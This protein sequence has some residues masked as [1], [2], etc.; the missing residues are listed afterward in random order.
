[1]TGDCHVR[2]RERL[3]GKL[4]GPTRLAIVTGGASGIGLAT[5]QFFAMKQVKVIAV[6]LNPQV[7]SIVKTIDSCYIGIPG[8]LTEQTFRQHVVDTTIQT[9]GRIDILV[10][11]AGVAILN[12]AEL[13]TEDQWDKTMNINL[14]ASFMIAQLVGRRMISQGE[15]SIVNISSQASIVALDEH[16]AY[17]ASKAAIVSMSQVMA[18]E[19][20]NHGI[21]VNCISPTIV[22]TELGRNAWAGKKGEDMKLQIPA[23]RFAETDE[24]AASIAFLC[25]NA[26]GMITGSNLIIDG[27]YTAR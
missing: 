18:Y 6:D 21:R 8:D 16:V 27:G 12:K 9:Y 13:I 3:G 20:G 4:P 14:K 15:G 11:S 17:C 10:N 5:V 19:W 25:S 26:A 24:I 23:Q 2:F 1:M 22:M 7:D